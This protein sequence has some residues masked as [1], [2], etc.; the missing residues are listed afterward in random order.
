LFVPENVGVGE[1]EE[2]DCGE[3]TED[4]ACDC[5]GGSRGSSESGVVGTRSRVLMVGRSDATRLVGTRIS[6]SK[7]GG[8]DLR[9]GFTYG[10][11]SEFRMTF[12]KSD[13]RTA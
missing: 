8:T 9:I 7:L 1:E 3:E 11:P 4:F 6:T 10:V 5:H 13:C 2:E 12:K